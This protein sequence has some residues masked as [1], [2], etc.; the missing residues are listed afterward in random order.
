MFGCM[1][2]LSFTT[3]HYRSNVLEHPDF[4]SF[5]LKILQKVFPISVP[6]VPINVLHLQVALL[7]L[8]TCLS[9]TS[10]TSSMGLSLETVLSLHVFK[11][12]IL[13]FFPEVGLV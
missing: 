6:E 3:I 4:S 7:S 8:Y 13:F 12:N 9:S 1:V 10:Q 11:L 2:G 5:L